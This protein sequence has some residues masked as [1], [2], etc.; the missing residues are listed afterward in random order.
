MGA[1]RFFH[2]YLRLTG[3]PIV[4]ELASVCNARCVWCWM[5]YTGRKPMGLM[6]REKFEELVASNMPLFR[7]NFILPYY[8]G[9]PLL[10][11]QFAEMLEFAAAKGCRFSDIHSNL[12]V[13]CDLDRLL[14]IPIPIWVVNVGGITREVHEA[15]MLQSRWDV[16]TANLRRLLELSKKHGRTVKVKMNV[17]RQNVHQVG[18]FPQWL[19]SLGAA[20]D[21]GMLGTVGL[22][23]PA[24]ATP[25]ETRAFVERV[26]S[27]EAEPFLRFR[28]DPDRPDFGIRAKDRNTRCHLVMP[29]V[30]FDGRVSACCHDQLDAWVI[31]NAFQENLTRILSS[32]RYRAAAVKAKLRRH[33]ICRE[34][35]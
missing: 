32:W 33:A 4:V 6:A 31:G 28:Y 1:W 16:V 11:P 19:R 13:E 12:S 8:R 34:C 9:E 23:L 26:A 27:A 20:E 5:Y 2:Q 18:G 29:V 25:E 22:S 15:V 21:C 35:N 10:H 30:K 7:R 24:L 3:L 17:T 14:R